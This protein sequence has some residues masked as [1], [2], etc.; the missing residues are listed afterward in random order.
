MNLTKYIFTEKITNEL[1]INTYIYH[2]STYSMEIL[3]ETDELIEL[4]K[5]GENGECDFYDDEES[6]KL[7]K[8][9]YLMLIKIDDKIFSY[10][11]FSLD[12]NIYNSVYNIYGKSVVPVYIED[13]CSFG[14]YENK[15]MTSTYLKMNSNNEF[16]FGKYMWKM[17][18]CYLNLY[19]DF[20]SKEIGNSNWVWLIFCVSTFNA[21]DFHKRNMMLDIEPELNE[22]MNIVKNPNTHLDIFEMFNV[23]NTER[24]YHKFHKLYYIY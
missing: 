3:P 22:L 1:T 6:I 21:Y 20:L 4:T 8:N 2:N 24:E 23:K 14:L 12:S 11:K 16:S 5:N 17:L 15:L 19:K 18:L 13:E 10:M 9:E 7:Y